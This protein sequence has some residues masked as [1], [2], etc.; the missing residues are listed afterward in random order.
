MG[1]LSLRMVSARCNPMERGDL[2][3]APAPVPRSS[4][5]SPVV[6]RPSLGQQR[7]HRGSV[8]ERPASLLSCLPAFLSLPRRLFHIAPSP[9]LVLSTSTREISARML[10]TSARVL[11]TSAPML[12]T[13]AHVLTACTRVPRTFARV[14][15]LQEGMRKDS[16]TVRKIPAGSPVKADSLRKYPAQLRTWPARNQE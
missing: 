10:K 2:Q 13:F 14:R 1:R 3:L 16:A 15:G 8:A 6:P 5:Q 9:F 12:I 11:K 7:R 4:P